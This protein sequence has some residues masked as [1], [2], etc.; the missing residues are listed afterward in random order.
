MGSMDPRYYHV[1]RVNMTDQMIHR[2][3]FQLDT[4]KTFF[5]TFVYKHNTD[6]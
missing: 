1:C 5:I 2:K 3:G 4:Q 6:N